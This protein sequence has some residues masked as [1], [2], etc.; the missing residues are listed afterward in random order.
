MFLE[1]EY[2]FKKRIKFI[3]CLMEEAFRPQSWLGI[4]KGS[5]IHIDFSSLNDFNQSF[6]QLIRQINFI[7]K[8]YL[9]FQFI[10]HNP[11]IHR[12]LLN[13]EEFF[14]KQ[15]IHRTLEQNEFLLKLID[16]LIKQRDRRQNFDINNIIK[17]LLTVAFLCLLILYFFFNRNKYSEF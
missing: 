8:N 2:A 10:E 15:L 1:V 6:E 4:I 13:E 16:Q 7:E 11:S 14:L 3:P 9:S 5:N 12:S 17:S